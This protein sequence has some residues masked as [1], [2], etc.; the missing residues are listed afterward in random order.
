[1]LCKRNNQKDDLDRQKQLMIS[2][3]P[4]YIIIEDTTSLLLSL[5]ISIDSKT[6][7]NKFI[8]HFIALLIYNFVINIIILPFSFNFFKLF[9]ISRIIY[10]I[11]VN[12]NNVIY[13]EKLN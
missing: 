3:Y 6:F 10:G 5:I 2:K 13:D 4:E 8:N 9:K 7:D 11:L 12:E 1:M